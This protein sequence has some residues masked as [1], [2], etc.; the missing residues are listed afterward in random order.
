MNIIND[1]MLNNNNNNNK[2]FQ[3]VFNI[4][5]TFKT[6]S[7]NKISA[8]RR[9]THIENKSDYSVVDYCM[10]PTSGVTVQRLRDI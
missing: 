6:V 3:Y 9:N 2:Q 5:N 1:S 8:I 7:L 10:Q 4:L